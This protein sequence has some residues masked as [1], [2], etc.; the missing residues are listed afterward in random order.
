MWTK[1]GFFVY[2]KILLY[3]THQIKEKNENEN[4]ENTLETGNKNRTTNRA[5]VVNIVMTSATR[6]PVC[7]LF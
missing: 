5:T 1:M 6:V 2:N 7:Y 4:P 3:S